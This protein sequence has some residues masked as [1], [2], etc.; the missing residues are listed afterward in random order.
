MPV[1]D[2]WE[3]HADIEAE[4]RPEIAVAMMTAVTP[5]PVVTLPAVVIPFAATIV[6]ELDAG[7]LSRGWRGDYGQGACRHGG[8]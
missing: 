6:D 1:I 3:G 5:A 4:A 7:L 2:A 8:S